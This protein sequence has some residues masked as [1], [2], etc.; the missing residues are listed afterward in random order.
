MKKII[1]LLIL[2]FVQTT[3]MAAEECQTKLSKN[4]D[5]KKLNEIISCLNNR[6][7]YL[8]SKNINSS[9]T[10]II[11]PNGAELKSEQVIHF[12]GF[13]FNLLSCSRIG[14]S[15]E[16]TVRANNNQNDRIVPFYSRKNE[17]RAIDYSGNEYFASG[18]SLGTKKLT[19]YTKRN[20]VNGIPVLI[21]LH[22]PS[23]KSDV[24]SFA[25]VEIKS[26]EG[27]IR[28]RDVPII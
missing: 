15:V 16:C 1:V 8:E 25:L 22:Y 5:Y 18:L 24:N 10:V 27:G 19:T 12:A 26:G 13:T 4:D 14:G 28:F 21:T 7:N 9:K 23:V 2:F 20:F 17:T 3:L 11:K 6:I